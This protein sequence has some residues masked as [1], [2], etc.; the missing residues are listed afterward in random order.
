MYIDLDGIRYHVEV[1]GK[2]QTPLVLLHGFTGDS[3][4]WTPFTE[5]WGKDT[6]L[7]IPD[8]IGHGKTESPDLLHSYHIET[9]ASDLKRILDNLGIQQVDLLGYSMG[10]RLALTFAVLFPA[11]VRKLILE[12]TSPGLETES[13][14]KQRRMKDAELAKFI[15]EQGIH[16]FVGYWEEIPLFSTMKRL[17]VYTQQKIRNQRLS[18]SPIGLSNSLL[19]MGTGSQPSLWERLSELNCEVL[20]LTG[21]EDHKFCDIAERMMKVLKNSILITIEGSGHAIHVEEPEK[22]GTIVSDFLSKQK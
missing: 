13:D 10:G 7:I 2:G 9:A 19:G 4:T 6:K 17:P 3:T 1:C 5:C 20:L 8:I 15:N 14:R 22:F 18:N 12:S 21:A 11:H 16:A